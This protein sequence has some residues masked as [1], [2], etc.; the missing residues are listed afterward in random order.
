MIGENIKK[1]VY[2]NIREK[3]VV[4]Y[5]DDTV[6]TIEMSQEEYEDILKT[7]NFNDFIDRHV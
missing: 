6:K 2:N 4:V 3:L 1:L 5:N 7:G